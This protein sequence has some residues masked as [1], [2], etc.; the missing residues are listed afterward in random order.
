M[1]KPLTDGIRAVAFLVVVADATAQHIAEEVTTA[2][3]KHLQEQLETFNE[4]VEKMRDA[5]E[6]IREA[7]KEITDRRNEFKE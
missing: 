7:A 4:N 1:P 2:A 5:V 6:H 3:K